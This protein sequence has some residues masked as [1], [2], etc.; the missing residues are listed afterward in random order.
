MKKK[1]TEFLGGVATI[2][3]V[4][5]VL[6]V[7]VFL[8]MTAVYATCNGVTCDTK[9]PACC[10]TVYYK[11]EGESVAGCYQ[12][13]YPYKQGLCNGSGDYC[14]TC[15]CRPIDSDADYPECGCR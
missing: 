2:C 11:P 15:L 1:R 7:G 3:W 14:N 4:V 5:G 12:Q 9:I 13:H 8:S 6:L 10:T